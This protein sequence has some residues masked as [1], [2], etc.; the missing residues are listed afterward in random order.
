M[1]PAMRA[2]ANSIPMAMPATAP[3]P[4]PL[5]AVF[6]GAAVGVPPAVL[7]VRF[8]TPDTA[9]DKPVTFV[10]RP[11]VEAGACPGAELGFEVAAES[12]GTP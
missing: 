9:P 8:S 5:L 10:G 1:K 11:I 12:E 7:D 3:P 2:P 6:A 4:S